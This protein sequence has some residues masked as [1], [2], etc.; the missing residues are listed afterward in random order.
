M[1]TDG[2]KIP[3]GNIELDKNM[4]SQLD[5]NEYVVYKDAQVKLRYLVQVK[6][7]NYSEDDSSDCD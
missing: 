1:R 6:F 5:L 7:K 3:F 4:K 2:I